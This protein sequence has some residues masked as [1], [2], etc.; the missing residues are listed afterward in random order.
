MARLRSIKPMVS[1][2]PTRQLGNAA[3][4]LRTDIKRTLTGGKLQK[5]RLR[6]WTADPHCAA[7]GR[8]VDYPRGFE[9]DHLTPVSLG[10]SDEDTNLQILCV[11]DIDPEQGCHAKK[12]RQEDK[13]RLGDRS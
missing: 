4:P 1:R 12:T 3:Q 6:L 10:G 5:T 8:L 2:L 7:C 13:D 9:L 11:D